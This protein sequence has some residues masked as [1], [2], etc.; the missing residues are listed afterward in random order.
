[1]C[2]CTFGDFAPPTLGSRSYKTA[3]SQGN[4]KTLENIKKL[5]LSVN[6]V[7]KRLS[8]RKVLYQ[9]RYSVDRD[10]TATLRAIEAYVC[11]LTDF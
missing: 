5:Y 7:R 4:S 2:F 9:L 6:L 8:R 11:R 3:N 10:R 1:M